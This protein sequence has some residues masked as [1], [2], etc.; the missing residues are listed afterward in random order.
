MDE[1]PFRIRPTLRQEWIRYRHRPA[2]PE[3]ARLRAGVA[4]ACLPSIRLAVPHLP[5]ERVSD[6]VPVCAAMVLSYYG[7]HVEPG[8]LA[9]VLKTDD[10]H[11]TPGR[12]LAWLH[13][14]GVRVD[15]PRDLQFF[16][17]G[18]V[19]LNR[20]MGADRLRLVFR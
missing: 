11:G 9:G 12:R 20:Q 13:G 16:R 8:W 19:E 5:Q 2:R 18:T 7:R 10:L 14:W 17:D 6:S 4:G 3:E 15:F 1:S